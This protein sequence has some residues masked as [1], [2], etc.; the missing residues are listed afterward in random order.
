MI[1]LSLHTNSKGSSK[2]TGVQSFS[3]IS[4]CNTSLNLISLP[5]FKLDTWSLITKYVCVLKDDATKKI[6][7]DRAKGLDQAYAQQAEQEAQEVV[8]AR[9]KQAEAQAKKESPFTYKSKYGKND[10][11][12]TLKKLKPYCAKSSEKYSARPSRTDSRITPSFPSGIFSAA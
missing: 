1:Y 9:E 10:G 6:I 8:E 5:A 11:S 12:E 7:E 3:C 2:Y 4:L